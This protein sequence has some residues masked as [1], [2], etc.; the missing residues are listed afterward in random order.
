MIIIVIFI[1]EYLCIDNHSKLGNANGNYRGNGI[2]NG[3][4][5]Q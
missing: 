3:N 4:L 2:Y 5:F 1:A